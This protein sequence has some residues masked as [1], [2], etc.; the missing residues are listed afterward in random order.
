GRARARR[1]A[2]RCGTR[3][4]RAPRR[5]ARR[6]RSRLRAQLPRPPP[7]PSGRSWRCRSRAASS[8]RSPS[9]APSP[10]RRRAARATA[11][12]T[13][14]TP[15][16]RPGRP[17]ARE[18]EW[19]PRRSRR[20]SPRR[21]ACYR[22]S[23]PC[24]R[25]PGG[26]GSRTT[27]RPSRGFAEAPRRP[28]RRAS[29]RARPPRPGRS[30]P[31]DPDRPSDLLQ[32][33]FQLRQA[34]GALVDDRRE[35]RSL[36]ANGDCIRD[37]AGELEVVAVARAVGV[38]RGDEELACTVVDG[39]PS[40]VD[41][42]A[43][44]RVPARVRHDLA[45][46]RVDRAHDRLRAERVRELGQ[47]PWVV[48]R[49]SVHGH[50]VGPGAEQRKTVLNRAHA[51]ADGERDREPFGGAV[52][53]LEQRAAVLE[54]RRDVEEDELV[55]AQLR[56]P[57]RELDRVAHVSQVLEADA[58]DDASAGD[59]EARDHALLDHRRAFSRQRAP[60]GPLRSGWNWTPA[61]APAST[62]ATT[63][64]SWSTSAVTTASSSGTAA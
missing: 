45:A 31:S 50:L 10:A 53:Q 12:S 6:S 59:V 21:R 38:D 62:A 44:A 24:A 2:R 42:V 18:E 43:A 4:L 32:V 19:H 11:R 34:F 49:R 36:G 46:S 29:A 63:G 15:Y 37:R 14:A 64:P 56:V 52:D 9:A 27:P 30:P 60:A 16:G 48:E 5:G 55:G 23:R 61:S 28:S 1:A 3:G 41:G 57:S 47:Q 8:R 51:A 40:P 25:A 7:R 17:G 35:E 54:R 58:L 33:S 22:T 13:T 26:Y 20:G 39:V